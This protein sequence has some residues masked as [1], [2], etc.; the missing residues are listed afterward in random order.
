VAAAH[1]RRMEEIARRAQPR[2]MQLFQVKCCHLQE[3]G[4]PQITKS[5]DLGG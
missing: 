1:K 5:Q 2:H 3:D 4:G